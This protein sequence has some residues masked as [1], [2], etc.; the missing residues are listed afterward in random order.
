MAIYSGFSHWKWWF[1]I[2][3]LVY[4]R[5]CLSK[6]SFPVDFCEASALAGPEAALNASR[7]RLME[8]TCNSFFRRR[9][10][11]LGWWALWSIVKWGIS[12]RNDEKRYKRW[13]LCFNFRSR[14][15]H[16]CLHQGNLHGEGKDHKDLRGWPG[17]LWS[18][19]GW[20]LA[21]TSWNL[22]SGYD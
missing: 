16:D 3:I 13:F 15:F 14:S 12:W 4:Q 1:S 10:R 18:C 17:W 22:T 9:G 2:V 11:H 5:V 21:D 8:V 20:S 6:S 19:H 7:G